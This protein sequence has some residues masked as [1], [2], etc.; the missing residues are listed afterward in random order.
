MEDSCIFSALALEILQLCTKPSIW[1]NE[2][3]CVVS[4]WL[5]IS[6]VQLHWKYCDLPRT[7]DM[8]TSSLFI[9]KSINLNTFLCS[10]TRRCCKS[11]FGIMPK[12][13]TQQSLF[14]T[15]PD[16]T[17]PLQ[18]RHNEHDD[19][20]NHWCLSGLL[21]CLFRCRSK[22][23]STE[24]LC[25]WPLWGEF[26]GGQW[27]PLTRASNVKN[28]SIWWRHHPLDAIYPACFR[29]PT[30][31]AITSKIY[32]FFNLI[33]LSVTPNKPHHS[34]SFLTRYLTLSSSS[35]VLSKYYN[36]VHLLCWMYFVLFG[37]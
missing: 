5:V 18:W 6:P 26:T 35:H 7:I 22:K 33:S 25:H 29:L 23:T 21:N 16:T 27:I 1:D 8:S 24:A 37:N 20:S 13:H 28:V 4:R 32:N 15:Q 30:R 9:N 14:I 3:E 12:L 34:F 10:H 17:Q 2:R 11:I 31:W 36:Q 19:I